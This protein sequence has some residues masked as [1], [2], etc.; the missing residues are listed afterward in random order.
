MK[1]KKC[2]LK[3]KLHFT[4]FIYLRKSKT[5]RHGLNNTTPIE[6]QLSIST[7]LI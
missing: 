1:I 6:P 5:H 3:L 2:N 4:T 7:S